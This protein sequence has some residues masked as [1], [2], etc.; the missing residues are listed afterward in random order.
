METTMKTLNEILT[1]SGLPIE[2]LNDGTV[3]PDLSGDE[4]DTNSDATLAD[5][6]A[7]NGN[8]SMSATANNV[9]R[10]PGCGGRRISWTERSVAFQTFEQDADGISRIGWMSHGDIFGV[11]GHCAACGH[12]WRARGVLMVTQ[13]PGYAADSSSRGDG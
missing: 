11:W 2:T 8:G 9:R 10:C 5:I 13:L 12:E 4:P 3:L 7:G 6:V 1:A